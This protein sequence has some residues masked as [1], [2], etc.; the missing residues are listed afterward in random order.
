MEMIIFY[1]LFE[2]WIILTSIFLIIGGLVKNDRFNTSK[3]LKIRMLIVGSI[4]ITLMLIIRTNELISGF[5]GM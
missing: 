3:E 1:A 2:F 4:L 5:S